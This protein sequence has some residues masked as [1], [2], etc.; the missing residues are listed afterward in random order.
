MEF[1]NYCNFLNLKEEIKLYQ[2]EN[3]LEYSLIFTINERYKW[4]T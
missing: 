3:I 1:L 4:E 2:L